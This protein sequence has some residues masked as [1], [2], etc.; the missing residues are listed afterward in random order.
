[1]KG[2]VETAL[3]LFKVAIGVT[4]NKRDIYFRSMLHATADEL[5]GRGVHLD[6]NETEDSMLLSDYA[7]F[8]Y[9]NRDGE[10]TLPKNLD[11]RIKNRKAKGRAERGT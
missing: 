3:M 8:N 9:R 2:S 11:I 10:K 7:E 5:E 4:H 6:L 1:M